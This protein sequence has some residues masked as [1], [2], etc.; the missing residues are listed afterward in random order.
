MS[1][2]R[3]MHRRRLMHPDSDR[4]EIVDTE[5]K[6]IAAPI[7]AHHIERMMPVMDAIDSALFLRADQKIPLFIPWL[8]HLRPADIPLAIGRMLQQLSIRAEIPAGIT[9]RAK[10]FHDKKPV[11]FLFKIDL[12]DRPPRNY[13][14]IPIPEG[15]LAI[16]RLQGSAA[17]MDKDQL[18]GIG[19]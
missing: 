16:H 17:M 1:L 10:R 18:I 14:V 8:H 4:L 11:I 6:R 9:N 19:I 15:Q 7:P 13:Q 3:L 12:I 5:S 2:E